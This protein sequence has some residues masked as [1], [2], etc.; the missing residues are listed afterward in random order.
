VITTAV[1]TP[2]TFGANFFKPKIIANAA[3]PIAKVGK[4]VC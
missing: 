1:N 3:I 4:C 2:G